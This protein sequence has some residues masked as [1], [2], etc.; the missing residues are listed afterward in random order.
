MTEKEKY[1][2]FE[3]LHYVILQNIKHV[4]QNHYPVQYWKENLKITLKQRNK[5]ALKNKKPNQLQLF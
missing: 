3:Y 2:Y 1:Y 5:Y 4:R